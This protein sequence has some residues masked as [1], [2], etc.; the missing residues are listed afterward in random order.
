MNLEININQ[1]NVN[2]YQGLI[3]LQNQYDIF[4]GTLKSLIDNG[5][6]QDYINELNTMEMLDLYASINWAKIPSIWGEGSIKFNHNGNLIKEV[7]IPSHINL[8]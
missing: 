3:E 2:N 6:S 7:V 1:I 5:S 4:V 8:W